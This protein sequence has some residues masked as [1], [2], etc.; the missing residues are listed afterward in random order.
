MFQAL[1]TSSL[2]KVAPAKSCQPPS[3][4]SVLRAEV[5]GS[6]W[7]SPA[8]DSVGKSV[9]QIHASHGVAAL[10]EKESPLLLL[11]IATPY[12]ASAF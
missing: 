1:L 7:I 2:T 8:R 11:R 4:S 12:T 10:G 5:E 3:F 9:A 6:V